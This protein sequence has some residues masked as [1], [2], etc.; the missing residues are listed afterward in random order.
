MATQTE[1]QKVIL[2][3]DGAVGSSYAYSMVNQGIAQEIG[4][5]DIAK[6]KTKGDAID[7]SDALAYT[8]PKTIYSAEYSDAKD[9]DLVV[10]TAGAPQKP[11]ETRLDLVSKNLKILKS[12]VDPI[13]ESGFDG[14]FLVAANPVDILTYAT[15]KLSGFPKERVIGSGT[16]L[17]SARL[18]QRIGDM[19]NVNP[20]SVHAYM[21]GEHGDTEFV[22]WSHANVGGVKVTDWVKAQNDIEESRLTEIYEDVRDAAYKIINMKGATFYGIGASLARITKAI[23]ND[24][25]SV[26]PL[27]VFMEGQYG[28]NDIFIG[29]PAVIGRKGIKQIIEMPLDDEESQNMHASAKQLKEIVEKGFAETGIEG[30]Q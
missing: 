8:A 30:R 25:N 28:V 5:V 6:D 19:M 24:E 27:S 13:V 16:S 21:L 17:D 9:A 1:R 26:L 2:V 29:A 3:G 4:I 11:G 20:Q 23:F 15:W 12:I 14:L 22:A 7:L 18:R 10:I